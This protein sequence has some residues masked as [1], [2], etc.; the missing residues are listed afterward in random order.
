M[1]LLKTGVCSVRADWLKDINAVA[2][3]VPKAE[4]S[5]FAGR[6]GRSVGLY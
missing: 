6:W 2:L 4:S 5:N 3:V 1:V